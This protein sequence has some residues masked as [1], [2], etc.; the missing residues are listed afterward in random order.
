M[1]FNTLCSIFKAVPDN[2]MF[3]S[4]VTQWP[5]GIWFYWLNSCHCDH[6]HNHVC[7]YLNFI[8]KLSARNK[9]WLTSLEHLTLKLNK[10]CRLCVCSC[11]HTH[12]PRHTPDSVLPPELPRHD[13]MTCFQL[14]VGNVPQRQYLHDSITSR[15]R[16][17]KRCLTGTNGPKVCQEITPTL[18]CHHEPELLVQ[19]RR[20]PCFHAVYN[21]FW[22]NRLNVAAKIKTLRPEMF[23]QFP[24]IP[25][26]W[27][28]SNSCLVL[29]GLS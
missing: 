18:W 5:W 13:C 22:S 9:N 15:L 1:G 26:W 2:C 3:L 17:L 8:T 28:C 23:S 19:G 6:S 10:R 11:P 16:M 20:D 12:T 27:A 21:M 14:G 25:F 7:T 4:F 29:S 24:I